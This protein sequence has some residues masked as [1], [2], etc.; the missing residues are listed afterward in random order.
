MTQWLSGFL[1]NPTMALGAAAVASPILI[2]LFARRR[3]QRIRWA[4]MS[5][6]LEAHRQNRRRIRLEQLILLMLRCLAVLL[7]ALVMARPF[8]QPSALARILGAAPQTERII[9]LDDSYSMDYRLPADSPSAGRSVFENA[10]LAVRRIV[11]WAGEVAPSD[12]MSLFVTSRPDAPI[13]ILPDLSEASLAHLEGTIETLQPS[14]TT[15]HMTEAV[16]AT[17]DLIGKRPTQAN[18]A[19]YIISDLR[20]RDWSLPLDP[21]TNRPQSIAEPLAALADEGA[22]VKLVLIDAIDGPSATAEANAAVLGL[23]ADQPQIVAGIPARFEVMVA[24]YSLAPLSDLQLSLSIARH[25]LP[26]VVVPELLPGQSVREPIEINYPVEGS[27]YVRVELVGADFNQDGVQLDNTRAL[28]VEV[29]PALQVL[30]IDGE[31]SSDAY[32]DEV[33]LLRTA[34][35]PAGRVASGNDVVVAD[36]QALEETDLAS[37]HIVILAN[38]NQCSKS[39]TRNLESF[40][41]AGGGFIVF[42][43]DQLDLDHYNAELFNDGAGLLPARLIG[44]HDASPQ[45]AG[46]GEWD[47][48]HPILRAFSG[49]LTEVLR[50]VQ[51]FSFVKVDLA[52]HQGDALAETVDSTPPVATAS[53]S[54]RGEEPQPGASDEPVAAP[55]R[56][57]PSPK[58]IAR[59][60]DAD[61]SPAIVQ[62]RFG[63]GTTLLVATSADQ[64]WNDWASNFTYLPTMLE[65][66]QF[67]APPPEAAGQTVVHGSIVCPF[68]PSV[69]QNRARLRNPD[70]PVSADAPLEAVRVDQWASA[71]E[72]DGTGKTGIYQFIL[73]SNA[74]GEVHRFA[75]VNPDPS[76]SNLRRVPAADLS[77]ERVG[78]AFELIGDLSI[79]RE[80]VAAAKQELWW[81]LLWVAV[82][83]LMMEQTLAWWFGTRG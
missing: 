65:L 74:K 11:R 81:P 38:V 22:S 55:P 31:P 60:N 16:R 82:A 66:V 23:I 7:L 32:R 71:F 52:A 68:D 43:G 58:V 13:V 18:T 3:F 15:A 49:R 76:E 17:A 78:M 10:K 56:P 50:S 34:L 53:D 64:E 37:F 73:Q 47:E 61:S 42:A 51:V 21:V 1:L 12:T 72:F 19:I 30:L 33:F 9:L 29:L 62:S 14:Q 40:V 44:V 83:I 80:Q 59:F 28:A 67:A 39:A 25:R 27:D 79:L 46:F 35:R 54:P 41:S 57:S 5:F 26:P 75:A 70:Y 36:E 20:E 24:N 4:A 63:R 48:T 69:F 8:L 77:E 45:V 6:L 2:H